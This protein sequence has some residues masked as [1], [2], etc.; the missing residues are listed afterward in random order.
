MELPFKPENLKNLL[1]ELLA[2][3]ENSPRGKGYSSFGSDRSL[4]PILTERHVDL[5]RPSNDS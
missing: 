1:F 4:P 2:K 3:K 5:K